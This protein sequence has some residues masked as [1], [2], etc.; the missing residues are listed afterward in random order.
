MS[1]R[2]NFV[3]TATGN[4]IYAGCQWGMI[5]ALAKLGSPEWV[6]QF[7]LAVALTAPVLLLTNLQLRAVQ[8]TDAGDEYKFGHYLAVRLVMSGAAA[9]VITA[10][11]FVCRLDATTA[12]IT[13]G[14]AVAKLIES[15]SDAFYG[16]QQKHERMDRVSVSMILRG[17]LSLAAFVSLVYLRHDVLSGVLAMAAVWLL[18]MAFY[19]LPSARHLIQSGLRPLWNVREMRR[20]TIIAAPL[21]V[22]MML[23]SLNVNIPRYALQYLSGA[24][25][26]GIFS[27]LAYV[28]IAESAIINAL[29]QSATP[30]LARHFASGERDKYWVL[31]KRLMLLGTA[32]GLVGVFIAAIGGRAILTLLYRAEYAEY[33]DVFMWLLLGAIFSNMTAFTGYGLTAARVFR[34]QVPLLVGESVVLTI[35][36]MLLVPTFGLRGAAIAFAAAKLVLMVLGSGLLIRVSRIPRS[37]DQKSVL[38][39]LGR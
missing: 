13:A 17:T 12:L 23:N 2:R 15:I 21:G 24:R 39:S 19:D 31:M 37:P 29:G 35:G 27:A 6:G 11:I 8:A 4:V 20:L 16:L 32:A 34:T 30:R 5:A 22:V 7:A 28:L 14:V 10:I 18:V 1:L 25:E 33:L 26:V 3:W 38:M 9:L 36:C